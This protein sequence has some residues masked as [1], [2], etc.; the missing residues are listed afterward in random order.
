MPSTQQA[1]P[2]Q[3]RIVI[4]HLSDLHFQ[5]RPANSHEPGTR[6][7]PL[8]RY[9]GFLEGLPPDRRPDLI[10]ITG[11]LTTTGDKYDLATIASI[12]RNDFPRWDTELAHHIF[13]VPGPRD[14]SWE[15]TG[16]PGLTAFYEEFHDFALPSRTHTLPSHGTTPTAKLNSIV[17]SLDTCYTLDE[18]RADLKDEFHQHANDYHEF[19]RRYRRATLETAGWF[20]IGKRRKSTALKD[21][22]QQYL[23][24]TEGNQL[25][26]L[27][28]GR[29]DP[30]DL[31][32]F[33]GWITAS[34]NV[35]GAANG[36]A[37]PLKILIT[38]HPLAIQPETDRGARP[39]LS[40]Q[41][42]F[43][44]VMNLAREAGFH[45][46]LHGHTHKPQVLSDLS[47]LEGTDTQHPLRQIGAGSL[48]DDGM[49]NEITAMYSEEE[50][51]RQWRLEIRTVNVLAARP[52]NAS[53]LVL[54]NPTEAAAEERERLKREAR[55]H[56]D[57]DARVRSLM[58]QYS[59]IIFLT[60]AEDRSER[61]R[62]DPLP[63]LPMQAVESIIRD[64]VFKDLSVRVRLLLKD[65]ETNLLIPRLK[66]T[67]L[68]PPLSDGP[69][70]LTYPASIAAWSLVLGRTL[71]FPRITQETL[72]PEDY[73]WLKR[74]GKVPEL[75]KILE[76]LQGQASA[77]SYP[78]SEEARRY[79]V[80]H[81]QLVALR[82]SEE[83]DLHGSTFYQDPPRDG[84][85]RTYPYFV[86]VPFPLRQQT[87]G[88]PSELHETAVLD[89]GVRIPEGTLEVRKPAHE[90]PF[91]DERLRML[92]S[93]S[94][95]IG[96]IL[97]T[98]SALG[99][100]RGVWE[101]RFRV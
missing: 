72:T 97:T 49:F 80:L 59:E 22:R 32:T 40:V 7:D 86:C 5:Q 18:F 9:R 53:S 92:E 44:R 82:D 23:Q 56:S 31:Q 67:Y 2:A 74:S 43:R 78:A 21:L 60:Q 89:V 46:A 71:V 47:I 85:P 50:G 70:T 65:K 11:D 37:E 42:R 54:L 57:F 19:V 14:V 75:I 41:Q 62:G 10:A 76:G 26:L 69:A 61:S 73:D 39:A 36:P 51:Q 52:D 15:G 77:R 83:A 96:M 64:V 91:T 20:G 55:T 98:S 3:Q 35:P 38:H 25:T 63:Q 79:E 24:L 99:K 87:G 30:A 101:D 66:A 13:I 27:D 1:E 8:V 16:K 68:A 34:G 45:L 81:D 28:A 48:G 84:S 95:L 94:E 33:T 90:S 88:F 6:Q 4:H 100:P 93:L 12:L 58:R 29:I 17:Y